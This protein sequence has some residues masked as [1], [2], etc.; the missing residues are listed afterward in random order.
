M[1]S[2]YKVREEVVVNNLKEKLNPQPQI[3]PLDEHAWSDRTILNVR[4]TLECIEVTFNS[5]YANTYIS[6]EDLAVLAR[7]RGF[8]LVKESEYKEMK[9]IQGWG[10]RG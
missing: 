7:L 1:G 8:Q 10:L 2:E 6:D 9:Q 4:N 3:K 5:L